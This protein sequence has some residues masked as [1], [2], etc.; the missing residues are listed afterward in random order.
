MFTKQAEVKAY[1]NSKNKLK[2]AAIRKEKKGG[3][4]KNHF[5]TWTADLKKE[6]ISVISSIGNR[7]AN[8]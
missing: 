2:I 3:S 6:R 5:G 8:K 1:K 7:H 4:R